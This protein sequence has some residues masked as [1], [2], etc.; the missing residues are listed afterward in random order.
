LVDLRDT[1]QKLRR[2]VLVRLARWQEFRRHIA[3]RTKLIFQYHLA[4]RGYYGKILF[5]HHN[6]TLN[7]K[8][9]TDDLAST[10]TREKDPKSLSGGEKSFSTIC[11]LLALWE[12]IGCPIRC[13]GKLC[14]LA[15]SRPLT[16]PVRRRV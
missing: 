2:S 7:L 3:L 10:Q 4:N 16:K 14:F 15:H 8:V 5:D 11:L 13:L 1:I 12:A 6:L 9:Q